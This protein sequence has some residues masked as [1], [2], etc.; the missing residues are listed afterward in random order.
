MLKEITIENN[1]K[2]ICKTK[3]FVMILQRV[4]TQGGK[5][6]IIIKNEIY[7]PEA[8]T[9][10]ATKTNSKIRLVIVT[11]IRKQPTGHAIIKCKENNS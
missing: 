1:D 8:A 2:A 11:C 10:F 5:D 9:I 7:L 6:F 4:I 3:T